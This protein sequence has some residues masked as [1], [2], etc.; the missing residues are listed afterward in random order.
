MTMAGLE[1]RDSVAAVWRCE[2]YAPAK[3]LIERPDLLP[4]RATGRVLHLLDLENLVGAS[5]LRHIDG[6]LTMQRYNAKAGIAQGDHVVVAASHHNWVQAA[7]SA[8]QALSDGQW[9]SFRVLPPRSGANG[10]DQALRE[11]IADE[12]VGG[13][14]GSVYLGSGDGIFADDLAALAVAGVR[15]TVVSRPS[16]LSPQLRLAA[17]DLIFL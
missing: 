5:H 16:A 12:N 9:C 17:E 4:R 14:F 3:L 10:A 6:K 13:R 8:R 11:V 7:F 1:M 15:T 2:A